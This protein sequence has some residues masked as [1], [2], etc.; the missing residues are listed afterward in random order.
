MTPASWSPF[1]TRPNDSEPAIAQRWMDRLSIAQMSPE[2]T[3]YDPAWRK[4]LDDFYTQERQAV[5]LA[6]AAAGGQPPQGP[7]GQPAHGATPAGHS[8]AAGAPNAVKPTLPHAP[9]GPASSAS[10][11]SPAPARAA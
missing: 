4:L 8:M 11:A 10:P 7:P 1:I 5:A 2:Y 9:N 6:Q 3:R